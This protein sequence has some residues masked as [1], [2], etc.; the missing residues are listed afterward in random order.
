MKN[1]S[2]NQDILKIKSV[3]VDSSETDVSGVI[4]VD[5][6]YLGMTIDELK[7][8]YKNAEFKNEPV[9]KY[10][11]DASE[12]G[13]LVIENKKPLFFVWTMEGENLIAGIII[14]SSKIII[15][16]IVHVGMTYAEFKKYKPDSKLAIDMID[17]S[18]EFGYVSDLQ[19]RVEFLTTD[20]TRVGEYKYDGGEP[21]FIK[22]VRPETKIERISL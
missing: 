19:Y 14:L 17:N 21:E 11:V 7:K 22:V 10:G 5:R 3:N 4:L 2:E 6:T 16:E 18:I 8:E 9:Y 15:D 1:T 20:S 13:I 12:D